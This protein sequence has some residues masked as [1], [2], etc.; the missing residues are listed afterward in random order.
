MLENGSHKICVEKSSQDICLKST[1]FL[2]MGEV[3]LE[4]SHLTQPNETSLT[5]SVSDEAFCGCFV[6]DFGSS[7]VCT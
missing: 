3:A 4:T 6:T 1:V 5:E 7:L 2:D